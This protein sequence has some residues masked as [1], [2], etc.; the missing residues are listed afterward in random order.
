MS[1][2]ER[3]VGEIHRARSR[4][5]G[6]LVIVLDTQHAVWLDDDGGRWVT[7][8]DEHSTVCNHQTR[9]LAMRHAPDVDWCE[10]CTGA[11]EDAP[12]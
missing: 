2:V 12:A 4:R 8:C 5:T 1:A 3:Y 6:T 9:K 10:E 7:L 11:R